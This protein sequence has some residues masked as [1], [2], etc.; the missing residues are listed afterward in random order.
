MIQSISPYSV[1][2]TGKYEQEKTPHLDTLHTD[3]P[4]KTTTQLTRAPIKDHG[5]WSKCPFDSLIHM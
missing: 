1:R 5:L 2:N 4:N 3:R